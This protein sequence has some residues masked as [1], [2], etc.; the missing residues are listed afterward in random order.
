MKDRV[1]KIL[2]YI[3]EGSLFFLI[4]FGPL[5]FGS[6]QVWSQT[7]VELVAFFI[8]VAWFLKLVIQGKIIIRKSLNIPILMFVG[9]I[10]FQMFPLP[11]LIL[12]FLSNSSHF[13]NGTQS[14]NP[15]LSSVVFDWNW[16]C[17]S[18][19]WYATRGE[20][21]K[22]IIYASVFLI[23]VNNIKTREQVE[24]ILWVIVI[25]GFLICIFAIIQ[26]FT[27]NGKIYWCK[28]II[29]GA[30]FGP[31]VNR[32]H[33]AG[34]I[35]LV[36]PL[37][38]GLMLSRIDI[39]KRIFVGFITTVMI[40][41]LVL[42]LSRGGVLSFLGSMIFLSIMFFFF[43]ESEKKRLLYILG[44]LLTVFLFVFWLDWAP[45]IKRLST[46]ADS[47]SGILSSRLLV[48]QASLGIVRKFPLFGTGLGTY[49]CTF[50]GYRPYEINSFFRHAHNDYL[51]LITETGVVG[52]VIVLSFFVLF[53]RQAIKSL[54][55]AKQEIKNDLIY[56]VVGL[57]I[58][59]LTSI[60]TMLLHSFID[61][62]L[63]I[64]ANALLFIIILGL[65]SAMSNLGK[66]TISSSVFVIPL[67]HFHLFLVCFFVIVLSTLFILP[68]RNIYLA[69]RYFNKALNSNNK[70]N[71]L[72]KATSIDSKNAFY[73]HRLGLLYEKKAIRETKS[74][75]DRLVLLR[76]AQSEIAQA[77]RLAP[78][79]GRYWASYAWLVGGL[80]EYNK[81]TY[82]FNQA[83]KL[84]PYN[85]VINKLKSEME[86]VKS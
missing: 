1:I 8:F 71:N 21:L 64:T 70:I 47:E 31:Y 30:P 14:Y 24:R 53:F 34:Y 69:D 15:T 52:F 43:K 9:L 44:I 75:R 56:S 17:L 77:I 26:K 18:V 57:I 12:K 51:Q 19:Y 23:I 45:V 80:G 86:R 32:D 83:I 35:N 59:G 79:I 82:F 39:S 4:I 67:R 55:S 73:H 33:F 16:R 2:D 28:K 37:S 50:P 68:I 61:F 78:S 62:N 63:H 42:S 85:P 72:E 65:V 25:G 38:F 7:V 66:D 46:I 81:A 49:F 10:L 29:H 76:Q 3:V 74:L 84:D 58:A 20:L 22:T 40:S 36:I 54:F 11:K 6:V 13:Y 5:A 41:T 60:I 27:W 48:W